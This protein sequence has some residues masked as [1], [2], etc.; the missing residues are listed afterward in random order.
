MPANLPRI[1]L[2][3]GEPAGIGPDIC[4]ALA[5]SAHAAEIV[6]LGD[7]ELLAARA[8]QLRLD[9]DLDDYV[10]ARRT[11]QAARHLKV[12]PVKLHA[13]TT[14]GKL[15]PANARYVLD[16]LDRAADGCLNGEFDAMVTAPVHKGVVNEAGIA[17]TGHT[18]Y[19]A[20]RCHAPAP[21]ML[22]TAGV[23]RVALATTHLP[24]AEVPHAI[25]RK[26]LTHTLRVL[27]VELRTGFG[28]ADPRILVL[29]LNP[30]AG[31]GGH[32]GREEI[33]VIA[34]VCEMLRVEGMQLTGPVAA[35]TAFNPQRLQ[36]V[37][38]VLAM[39]HD[40]GLPVLKY[41]GFGHAVN[42]TL[43]LPII[44]TS[45]DHGTALELAGTGRAEH[46][47]LE[48]AVACALDLIQHRREPP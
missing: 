27:H 37:D 24:L 39:Y 17:F 12:L 47:S 14:A 19:L 8:R 15:D 5:Q 43:G 45:V 23:L 48:A 44:R 29:G 31:E 40:Q 33:E 2:T 20:Q 7:P 13:P 25:T 16:L 35:D 32:L 46:S 6:A 4:I 9:L 41:G 38:A 10:P 22:L 1:A 18:E 11:A 36:N 26:S 3:T 21:V 28:V 30:H 34:P 42:I